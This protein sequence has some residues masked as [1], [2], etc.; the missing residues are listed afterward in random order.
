[1]TESS[2]RAE[3]VLGKELSMF[4][5]INKHT[6]VRPKSTRIAL[7]T[8]ADSDKTRRLWVICPGTINEP[9][10]VDREFQRKLLQAL[11]VNLGAIKDVLEP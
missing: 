6:W 3:F 11:D 5:K 9:L 8:N 4:L 2:L 10:E 7:M 1:M